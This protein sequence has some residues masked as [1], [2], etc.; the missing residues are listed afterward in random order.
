VVIFVSTWI[1]QEIRPDHTSS[2]GE[3]ADGLNW[4]QC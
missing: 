1:N 3:P 2:Y 4:S